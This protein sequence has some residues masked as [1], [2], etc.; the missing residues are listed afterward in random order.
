[1][2]NIHSEDVHCLINGVDSICRRTPV[3]TDDPNKTL[4]T[5]LHASKHSNI[6]VQSLFLLESQ[7]ISIIHGSDSSA[8]KGSI[9]ASSRL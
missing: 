9:V 2:S 5:K 3:E 8:E 4:D 7:T 6:P 1:M